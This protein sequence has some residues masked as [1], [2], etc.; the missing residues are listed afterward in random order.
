MHRGHQAAAA[1]AY[2]SSKQ[3][4][5]V[6]TCCTLLLVISVLFGGGLMA[7]SGL[8]TSGDANATTTAAFS[9]FVKL[10]FKTDEAKTT[11]YTAFTP[12]AEWI[13]VS[14]STAASTLP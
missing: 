9:L 6:L 10:T 13:K 1:N 11:F 8:P 2:E 4:R 7:S 14:M 3:S 5:G 12:L